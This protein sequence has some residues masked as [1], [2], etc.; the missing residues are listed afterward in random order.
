MAGKKSKINFLLKI[1]EKIKNKHTQKIWLF[2][3]SDPI[4]RNVLIAL[5]AFA[6]FTNLS[7][8]RLGPVTLSQEKFIN[9]I[10]TY[11][12]VENNQIATYVVTVSRTGQNKD[13]VT[14]ELSGDIKSM[15]E[16]V[17][18]FGIDPLDIKTTSSYVYQLDDQVAPVVNQK[19]L[20]QPKLWRASNSLEIKLKDINRVSELSALISS[21]P[22]VEVFGPDYYLDEEKIDEARMLANAI[23]AAEDKALFIAKNKGKSL[24]KIISIEELGRSSSVFNGNILGMGSGG[25]GDEFQP[26]ST[27]IT[28]TVQ[29][30][31]ELR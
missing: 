26:G 27:K 17:K 2:L 5:V 28:K 7:L 4:L 29:V 20:A 24:G 15:T 6:I 9:V 18:N 13:V 22:N 8:L 30:K 14:G 21:Q 16:L 25:E 11:T 23:D 19:G 1:Q 12:S 10:G 31:F 3:K